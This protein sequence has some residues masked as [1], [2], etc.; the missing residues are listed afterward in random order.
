MK[1]TVRA[2][3]RASLRASHPPPTA[4][5]LAA[6][7]LVGGPAAAQPEF[8]QR[9]VLLRATPAVVARYP[10]DL[11]DDRGTV[12][13]GGSRRDAAEPH[14]RFAIAY[15]AR[16]VD[17]QD[18]GSYQV[19]CDAVHAKPEHGRVVGFGHVVDRLPKEAPTSR[20][21]SAARFSRL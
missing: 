20:T 9:I 10:A 5:A 1:G 14:V 16:R 15:V 13:L 8:A 3:Q 18:L 19:V 21:R 2:V 11:L 12:G 7:L 6:L 17:R 4:F